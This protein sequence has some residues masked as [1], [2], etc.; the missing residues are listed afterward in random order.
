M[1][2]N[3]IINNPFCVNFAQPTSDS[4]YEFF[5]DGYRSKKSVW[6]VPHIIKNKDG[7]EIVT[8][9]CNWGNTCESKCV[10]AMSKER[11]L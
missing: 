4:C 1:A 10:Y 6:V 9:H 5:G 8:W 2:N 7:S 11:K 3:R